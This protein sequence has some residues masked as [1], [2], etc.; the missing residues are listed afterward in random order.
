MS[1]TEYGAGPPPSQAV[2]QWPHRPVYL[3]AHP[4]VKT[5]E[6]KPGEPLPL[7]VPVD[8]E[9]ELFK[10][11]FFCRLK[12]I[13]PHPEDAA[14]HKEYF[15]GK[16]RHYQWIVQGQFKEELNFSDL[17]IG[18]FY[19][20]PFL[21]IPKGFIM[22][23]YQKFMETMTPGVIMDLTSDSPKVLAA[24]GS[25]QTLRVDHPGQEPDIGSG[26]RIVENTTLLFGKDKKFSSES[27]RRSYLSKPKNSS[28]YTTNVD[29]VYTA[30]MY[31]HAMCIGSYY[32]HALGVKLD[33]VKILNGQPMG[34]AM[35]TRR[36]KRLLY[37]FPVWHERLL[38]E[39]AREQD[40][41]GIVIHM[42][43]STT[44]SV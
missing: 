23:L 29:Y 33:M 41:K 40:S 30:E 44:S 35:F 1:N 25:C 42:R 24:F 32:Q 39:M 21:G 36:D 20:R 14:G 26:D 34:F 6:Y 37:K 12:P 38:E 13:D 28:K 3:C 31:D 7:G 27:K 18:D 17:V 22:K 5:R 16:K 15:E 9:T 8:F 11:K 43:N 4:A 19:E 2:P 10:G